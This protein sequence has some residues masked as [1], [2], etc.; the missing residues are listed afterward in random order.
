MPEAA[1][2]AGFAEGLGA[3]AGSVVGHH[4]RHLDAEARVV[5]DGGRE[6]GDGALLALVGQDLREGQAGGVVD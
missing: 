5:S 6:E 1:I 4:P 2:A 3:I